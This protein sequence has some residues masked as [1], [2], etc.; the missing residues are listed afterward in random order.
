MFRRP[1][2]LPLAAGQ[3]QA[4][5]EVLR[6]LA[7]A[8]FRRPLLAPRMAELAA[9]VSQ[10]FATPED[11]A[12]LLDEVET[13]TQWYRLP[14]Y[15]LSW[16]A[17]YVTFTAAS[18]S[19]PR[20][21]LLFGRSQVGHAAEDLGL[22]SIE[23]GYAVLLRNADV[24][25]A[26]AA[27]R[28]SG[29]FRLALGS[30]YQTLA[31]TARPGGYQ[32]ANPVA[33]NPYVALTWLDLAA[34]CPDLPVTGAC[35]QTQLDAALTQWSADNDIFGRIV[36]R[37]HL[38]YLAADAGQPEQALRHFGTALAE[39]RSCGLDAEIGHL[40]RSLGHA[41]S[42]LGHTDE[43][44]ATLSAAVDHDAHPVH[45][46]WK[47]MDLRMLGTVWARAS[48]ELSGAAATRAMHNASAA[49]RDGR[50]CL[51]AHARLHL[52][53]PVSRMSALQLSRSSADNAVQV[54]AW[55]ARTGDVIGECE[56]NS[57]GQALD[58]LVELTEL[59][60][61]G[62]GQP[63]THLT[64]GE[65]SRR[66]YSNAADDDPAGYL[67][68][69]PAEQAARSR[70]ARWRAGIASSQQHEPASAVA[71]L[72]ELDA[73][74][75]VF[76]HVMIGDGQ[77][78]TAFTTSG[79]LLAAGWA[80]IHEA[81]L[82][83]AHQRYAAQLPA[84]E[85]LNRGVGLARAESALDELLATYARQLAP[86]L[87][88]VMP[89]L[90]G[91]HLKIFPR[92]FLTAV[93][94]HA[95]PVAGRRLIDICD[96]SYAQSV[97]LLIRA[98]EHAST[99][100]PATGPLTIVTGRDVPLYDEE[101]RRLAS[102]GAQIM[103]DPAVTDLAARAS[104]RPGPILFACHGQ[105]LPED[106]ASSHLSFGPDGRTSLTAMF[107]QLRLDQAQTVIMGACESSLGRA[108]I[109]SEFVGLPNVF[110]AAGARY[111]IGSLWRVN[112]LATV[113]LI[114]RYLQLT[115][116]GLSVPASLN[117][118]QREIAQLSRAQA[119]E[120][121]ASALPEHAARLGL[122]LAQMPEQPYAH[123]RYWSGFC[124]QGDL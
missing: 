105:Y 63:A 72:L 59:R 107:G 26:D 32:G 1:G 62:S 39:A 95:L 61:A 16:I 33:D 97:E 67:A 24:Y 9:P 87:E 112:A 115:A 27:G 55:L 41:Q 44:L 35:T 92:S 64:D 6:E 71:R 19:F 2:Q 47:A 108:E 43:A 50:E 91:R 60:S 4:L 76:M 68:A 117:Q 21:C 113:A 124:A 80:P 15:W 65:V 109:S 30:V 31:R 86:V 66:W 98:R 14:G 56:L 52:Y 84:P 37:R 121:V 82:R 18:P 46:Y 78:F 90:E 111:V 3:R 25:G 70:Y 10:A 116:T 118:A 122:Q 20:A 28:A 51:Q 85:L 88:P 12:R 45:S 48:Q 101:A 75:V 17:Q 13:L 74:G 110:I 29:K 22:D 34:A 11:H 58:A 79:G 123:P 73:P 81:D 102:S 5:A 38:G 104:A 119:L 120:W 54:A 96:V 106:P 49:F 36:A 53:L 40:L 103:R 23:R 100:P 114:D 93:P 77:L 94:L 7:S 83:A 8:G 57:P 42:A 99:Q 89:A 69:L